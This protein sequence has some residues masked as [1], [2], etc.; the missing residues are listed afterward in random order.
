[1]NRENLDRA[2][3]VLGLDAGG[4]SS[5]AWLGDLSGKPIATGHA[6]GGNPNSHP[7]EQ[8]AE[9]I[10]RAARSALSEVPPERVRYG[11]IGMAG[12]STM[13]D[14]TVAELFGR[15]WSGLGLECP[16]REVSD[17]E[18]AFAAGTPQPDGTVL[19]AGTGA[20]A[21]R[22]TAHRLAATSGGYGWLLGDEGSAFWLGREAVR[23][24][25]RALDGHA[26]QEHV[27]GRRHRRLD[28]LVESVRSEL[29]GTA[30]SPCDPPA[31]ERRR[32]I[33]AVN[34]AA[35]VR[36][37]EIA[38]L[39]TASAHSGS[40]AAAGIVHRAASLLADTVRATRTDDD[41]APIVL[42]GSLIAAGNPVRAALETELGHR[43]L[44]TPYTAGS[45]AVGAA[46][47]AAL[48]VAGARHSPEELHA[49]FF[50]TPHRHDPA[51]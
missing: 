18:V 39:V 25:L 40:V 11:V 44:G 38:P 27:P 9:R 36:L 41:T 22:I 7:P 2:P 31:E 6:G 3:L 34:A 33:T 32:L 48:E 4:T 1:M 12:V 15:A 35:P 43:G 24:T 46:W 42:A 13:A 47:L 17:C 16:I 50:G 29:L 51:R 20:I 5:R 14:P 10:T 45:G 28:P 49:R 26:L 37:A 8:A 23:E 30:G 21:A 19:I